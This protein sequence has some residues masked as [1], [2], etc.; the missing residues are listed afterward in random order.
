MQSKNYHNCIAESACSYKVFKISSV[1]GL[2]AS[3]KYLGPNL[4]LDLIK[5]VWFFFSLPGKTF[6]GEMDYFV[7]ALCPLGCAGFGV[8][9]QQTSLN[10]ASA[11]HNCWHLGL[12]HTWSLLVLSSQNQVAAS[13]PLNGC[14]FPESHIGYA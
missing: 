11:A 7:L 14:L 2:C 5:M 3:L 9:V 12:G 10:P 6:Q 1:L 13:T 4:L 8:D